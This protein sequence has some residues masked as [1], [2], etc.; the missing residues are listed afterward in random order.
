MS[1]GSHSKKMP[2]TGTVL[3]NCWIWNFVTLMT[4]MLTGAEKRPI[5][6]QKETVPTRHCTESHLWETTTDDT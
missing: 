5:Q 6:Q 1:I 2:K 3:T 4:K